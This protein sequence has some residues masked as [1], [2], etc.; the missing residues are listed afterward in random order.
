MQR[1]HASCQS[2]SLCL[3]WIWL[4]LDAQPAVALIIAVER[5]QT[6]APA[7]PYY[8]MSFPQHH[9]LLVHRRAML[10]CSTPICTSSTAHACLAHSRAGCP[11]L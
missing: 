1:R 4:H 9:E 10:P 3:P 8:S 7:T 2:L 11:W 6:Y 5:L